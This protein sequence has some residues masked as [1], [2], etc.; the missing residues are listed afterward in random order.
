MCAAARGFEGFNN[1]RCDEH[2]CSS[3]R[4]FAW[5]AWPGRSKRERIDPAR[6]DGYEC[7]VNMLSTTVRANRVS[8][9]FSP[10]LPTPPSMRVRTRRLK[11][12]NEN[13]PTDL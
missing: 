13:V 4:Y 6:Q 5:L 2:L 3:W 12:G 1:W 11:Q 10:A 9:G 7:D 8:A